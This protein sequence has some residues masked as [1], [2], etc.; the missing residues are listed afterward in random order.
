VL[1]E[2]NH[3]LRSLPEQLLKKM[4]LEFTEGPNTKDFIDKSA[5]ITLYEIRQWLL[6]GILIIQ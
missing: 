3:Y 4:L 5:N 6:K 1:Y 2:V